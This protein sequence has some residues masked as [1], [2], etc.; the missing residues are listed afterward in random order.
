MSQPGNPF[1]A[2][3]PPELAEI[4]D[5]HRG[6]FGGYTMMADGADAGAAD[7][8]LQGA[9]G[10]QDAQ[11]SDGQS[12][13]QNGVQQES[14]ADKIARLT[15]ELTAARQEAGKS[16]VNAKETAAAE[17]R[18]QLVQELGKALGIV[19]DDTPP[20]PAVLQQQ[21]AAIA[22]ENGSLKGQ[23]QASETK[24]AALI[25]AAAQGINPA[26]LL[27]SNSFLKSIEGLAPTDA[28]KI[29][30]AIKTAS[31]QNPTLK[32]QAAKSGPE[33][34]GGTGGQAKP[35][36]LEEAVAAKLGATS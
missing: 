5:I 17:A 28:D 22:Y 25:T 23:L 18:N 13:A 10:A 26:A 16:R 24:L 12:D 30:A 21:Y 6:L 35:T 11:P 15:S 20:D 7:A 32:A 9:S 34:N 3:M 36:T 14:D 33:F 2:G 27:D 4:I 31:D 19:K 29:A 1:D 8:G